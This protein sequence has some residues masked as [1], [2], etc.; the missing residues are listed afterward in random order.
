[1]IK[2]KVILI[3]IVSIFFLNRCT[4][5]NGAGAAASTGAGG[6][7]ARFTIAGNNLYQTLIQKASQ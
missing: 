7:T 2:T 1:M 3:V 6:S 4:K 5:E